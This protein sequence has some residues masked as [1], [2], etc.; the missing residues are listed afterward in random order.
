MRPVRALVVVAV[1][2]AFW[3]GWRGQSVREQ[4][5]A[6]FG[7]A[8]AGYAPPAPPIPPAFALAPG[9][10][11]APGSAEASAAPPQVM[12]YTYPNA[13]GAKVG[14]PPRVWRVGGR[15]RPISGEPAAPAPVTDALVPVVARAT[16]PIP[17][18]R[19]VAPDMNAAAYEAATRAYAYLRVGDRRGA[20]GA[21]AVAL[22]LAPDHPNA[23]AW[24]KQERVL[25]KHWRVE[26]YTLVRQNDRRS[27]ASLAFTTAPLPSATPVLGAGAGAAT[28]AYT[29]NPLSRRQVELRVRVTDP[30]L[31][32]ARPDGNAAQGAAGVAFRPFSKVP[33]TLI[34]ERLFKLGPTARNDFQARLTAG[35]ITHVRHIDFS[36]F[37]EA[38]VVGRRPDWFAGVQFLAERPFPLPGGFSV[39]PGVGT[40][41]AVQQTDRRTSRIDIGP[42]IHLMP[43]K[44]PVGFS[45][46]YR[47]KV[48]GSARPGSGVAL[49][50]AG[51][52]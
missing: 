15:A 33:V 44:F 42:S 24:R 4:L 46:D 9:P 36:A 5:A 34:A 47:A 14:P 1:G 50:V 51:R 52:F 31:G 2:A 25:A 7:P 43:P 27:A 30:F 41:A 6:E 48:A 40:W 10:Q 49:T 38:G 39:A 16:R 12:V 20:A 21:F 8:P 45:V 3:A 22:S 17:R 26:A 32:L 28:L 37:G 18:A 11:A 13:P 19:E 23:A 35:T 29:L